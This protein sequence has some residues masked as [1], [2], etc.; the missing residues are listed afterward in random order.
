MTRNASPEHRNA[1]QTKMQ[2]KF[3]AVMTVA[4]LFASVAAHAGAQKGEQIAQQRCTGCHPSFRGVA[5]SGM[6]DDQLRA[7][8]TH[9]HGATSSLTSAEINDLIVYIQSLR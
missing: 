8:L 6:S 4:A 3:A 5:R 7:F 2:Y 1:A 9:S